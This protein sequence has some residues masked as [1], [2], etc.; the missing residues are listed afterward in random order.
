[1][2]A[3]RPDHYTVLGV[4][5]DADMD[6]IRAAFR[7]LAKQVHPDVV[8]GAGGGAGSEEA[9]ERFVRLQEAYY[10]LSDPVRRAQFDVERD[11]QA[12]MA[13]ATRL[14]IMPAP[15]P[16]PPPSPYRP[17]RFGT[18][19]YIGMVT[20]LVVSSAGVALYYALRP[21]PQI[22]VVKVEPEPR[23]RLRSGGAAGPGLPAD[24]GIL[25]KEV[26]RAVQAQMQRVE[27]AKRKLEQQQA[28]MAERAKAAQ[29]PTPPAGP[30]MKADKVSCGREGRA[31]VLTKEKDGPKIS[32]DGETPVVP[33]ISDLGNGAVLVS[34]IEATN[35]VAIAFTKGDARNTQ[36]L[37]FDS[38]GSVARTFTV[39]CTAAAF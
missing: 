34:R 9:T 7:M 28:E 35:K 29:P 1:M 14:P 8:T 6:A 16:K 23:T 2:H 18:W 33:R 13:R 25:S 27:E 39:E 5:P 10:V 19:L 17:G 36:I 3:Y 15:A 4:L 26:D 12:A 31:I 22:M 11:R 20:L 37:I 38:T 32:Y 24:P 21:K 30:V